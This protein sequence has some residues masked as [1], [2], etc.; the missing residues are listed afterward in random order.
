MDLVL[1]RGP[2]PRDEFRTRAEIRR[3]VKR[4]PDAVAQ[5]AT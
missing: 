2:Q 4:T 5:L 1:E 3:A